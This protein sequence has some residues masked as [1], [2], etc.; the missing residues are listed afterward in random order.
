MDKTTPAAR[1]SEAFATIE[2]LHDYIPADIYNPMGEA[3]TDWMV[4]KEDVLTNPETM[5]A[6]FP[7]M[8]RVILGES[9]Y[10]PEIEACRA[11]Y[12]KLAEGLIHMI[13]LSEMRHVPGQLDLEGY[14]DE[15]EDDDRN[16]LIGA[17]HDHLS[18]LWDNLDWFNPATM[19]KFYPEM[20]L[21][22]AQDQLNRN[23]RQ[24]ENGE[25]ASEVILR[26]LHKAVASAKELPDLEGQLRNLLGDLD[27]E[28]DNR[29][30]HA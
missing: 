23:A 10:S 9:E 1:L 17:L 14:G 5:R 7:G 18:A 22:I 6:G 11:D 15:E 13:A 8:L 12:E 29:L 24:A 26:K 30:V 25:P 16:H 20:R 3:I 27:C 19:R 2:E 4:N 28:L 21:H